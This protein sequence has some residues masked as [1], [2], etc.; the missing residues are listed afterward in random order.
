MTARIRARLR[1]AWLRHVECARYRRDWR[2]HEAA[3]RVR[4]G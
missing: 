1:L 2:A 4:S 3:I